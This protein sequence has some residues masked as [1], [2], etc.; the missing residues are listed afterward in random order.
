MKDLLLLCHKK[1]QRLGLVDQEGFPGRCAALAWNE[2][3]WE[4]W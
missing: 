4:Y 1:G 2:L 3:H